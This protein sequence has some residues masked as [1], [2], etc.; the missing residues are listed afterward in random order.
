MTVFSSGR[1]NQ[2]L[3]G[4]CW[5]QGRRDCLFGWAWVGENCLEDCISE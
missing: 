5:G 2:G 1:K 4:G 3:V